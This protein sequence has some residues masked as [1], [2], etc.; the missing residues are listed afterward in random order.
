MDRTIDPMFWVA[1]A[2]IWIFMLWVLWKEEG[3]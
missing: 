1:F 2:A 3:K